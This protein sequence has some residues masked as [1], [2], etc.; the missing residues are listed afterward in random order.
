MKATAVIG[1]NFGDEGKGLMTDYFAS[2]GDAIVIR[3]NGGAQAGH[4]VVVNGK[5]HVFKHFGS[6][7]LAG[8][9][10][11]LSRF[12][13]VNPMLFAKEWDDL[14]NISPK[15]LIYV[16]DECRVTTPFDVIMNQVIEEARR[17][18]RHGSCGIGF[19]ETITRHNTCPITV[20]DLKNKNYLESC[21]KI[22]RDSYV[23]NRL[24]QFGIKE[25]PE[26]Y[27]RLLCNEMIVENYLK[28]VD[29]FLETAGRT[30]VYDT[31]L[32]L[33]RSFENVI[34]EGAQGLLLDQDNVTC[35]PHVTCSKTGIHNVL[36][37]LDD[38]GIESFDVVY[39]TRCY[40]TRHGAGFLPNEIF[41]LPY[42]KVKDETNLPNKY[43][44]NL[45]FA[46][47]NLDVLF[48]S[49]HKDVKSAGDLVNT[50]NLAITCLDQV[51]DKVMFIQNGVLCEKDLNK[52]VKNVFDKVG[53][54]QGYLSFGSSRE[55]VLERRG[56][57]NSCR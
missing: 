37:L 24:V 3:F 40:L 27:R 54:K 15:P 8:A 56:N 49:I 6:G 52:F 7:T 19:H 57:E 41:E 30:E 16:D 46:W 22:I 31:A 51:E 26:K 36:L 33:T 12:F 55:E 4:T 28:D 1:A 44:G 35:F 29:L 34:F 10:T 9:P 53:C 45:R 32:H 42:S 50:V 2:K 13:V 43:Q 11:F 39:V 48:E 20:K 47:F 21:C 17:K 38:F 23:P 18:G 25:I 14:K 5:C